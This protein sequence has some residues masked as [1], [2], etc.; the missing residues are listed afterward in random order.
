[1]SIYVFAS[2]T[3][4]TEHLEAAEM[5]LR[6]AVAASR[7]EP[8]CLRYDLFKSVQGET[9]FQFFETYVDQ[10]ALA[11]HAQSAHFQTLK[12]QITPLLAKPL[13]ISITAAVDIAS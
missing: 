5:I 10:A 11:A 7:Q 1:M 4:K 6:Q 8:G 2:V 12:E 3:P 9:S 13:A